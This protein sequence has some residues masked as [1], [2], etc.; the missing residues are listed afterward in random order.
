MQWTI[1]GER[2]LY[3]SEWVR[4]HLVDVE[5]PGLRRFDHHVVRMPAHA[6]GA[7]VLDSDRRVLLLWRHRFITDRWGWE[8][9]SGRIDAGESPEE[10]AKREVLEETGWRV[11]G[12]LKPLIAYHPANGISDHTFHLFTVEGA[13]YVGVPADPSEAERVVWVPDAEVRRLVLTG[14]VPDG[15]TLTAL[16]F[17]MARGVL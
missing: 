2:S 4:L 12:A 16:L 9:P 5:V 13:E 8:V 11:T 10:A 3:D 6:A 15:L 7:V 17:A 14:A 1:H